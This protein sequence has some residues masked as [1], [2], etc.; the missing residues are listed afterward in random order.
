M[1]KKF[2]VAQKVLLCI[3][4]E[5]YLNFRSLSEVCVLCAVSKCRFLKLM[6]LLQKS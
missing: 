2:L 4:E 1:V 6:F 3:L 5:K